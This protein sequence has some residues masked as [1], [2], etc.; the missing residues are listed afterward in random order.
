MCYPVTLTNDNNISIDVTIGIGYPLNRI[1]TEDSDASIENHLTFNTVSV[2]TSSL[3]IKSA[4][5]KIKNLNTSS[6]NHSYSGSY[7]VTPEF[8]SESSEQIYSQIGNMIPNTPN[9]R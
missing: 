8:G 6:S 4:T 3:N 7:W 5:I 1:A 9:I 2:G